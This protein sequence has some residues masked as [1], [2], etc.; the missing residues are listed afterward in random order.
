MSFFSTSSPLALLSLIFFLGEHSYR[1][2]IHILYYA[3]TFEFSN[4]W[5]LA[6][7]RPT[8][9]SNQW[10]AVRKVDLKWAF[11]GH[12]LPSKDSVKSVYVWAGRQQW[13]ETCKA[14]LLMKNL[15]E[16]ALHLTGNWFGEPIEKVPI[17]LE[18]LRSLHLQRKWKIFL[19]PQPYYN[20]E[21][22]KLNGLMERENI[23]CE[24]HEAEQSARKYDKWALGRRVSVK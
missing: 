20:K 24:V 16:F 14:I 7:L 3:N 1:E 18:P 2:S 17:F 4:T 9:P 10:N 5:S 13:I 19:P 21:T 12:W 11:P 6:Y 22:T 15:E 23:Y 8:L